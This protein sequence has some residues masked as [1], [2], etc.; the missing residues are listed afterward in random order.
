[1]YGVPSKFTV[2]YLYLLSFQVETTNEATT[3]P[4][5]PAVPMEDIK[6]EEVSC[7]DLASN[8]STPLD[9]FV[10][11]NDADQVLHLEQSTTTHKT[12]N[13]TT[14]VVTTT[15]TGEDNSRVPGF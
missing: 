14:T 7:C 13:P 5:V 8:S 9:A 15:R 12:T 2:T 10:T 1:M 11:T 3:L 6:I 4:A